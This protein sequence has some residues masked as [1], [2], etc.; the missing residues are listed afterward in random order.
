MVQR[1]QKRH[2][3]QK[4]KMA[5]ADVERL[6][7]YANETVL[8]GLDGVLSL[9]E[10]QTTALKAFVEKEEDLSLLSAVSPVPLL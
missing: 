3:Q 4:R 8:N 9:K 7:V 1:A 2:F 5:A 6:V 10:E